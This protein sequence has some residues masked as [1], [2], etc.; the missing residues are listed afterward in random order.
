MDDTKD[1]LKEIPRSS[2]LPVDFERVLN[3]LLHAVL[4]RVDSWI[5]LCKNSD[6]L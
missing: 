6:I 4:Y 5:S 1:I 3:G 2:I